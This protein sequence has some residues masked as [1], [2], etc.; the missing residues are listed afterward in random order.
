MLRA[1]A[2]SDRRLHSCLHF[3]EIIKLPNSDIVKFHY[4]ESISVWICLALGLELGGEDSAMV[5]MLAKG[6]GA[7]ATL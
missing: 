4:W 2:R 1:R 3:L 5:L 6:V 7:I